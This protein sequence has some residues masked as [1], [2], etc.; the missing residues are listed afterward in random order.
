MLKQIYRYFIS[1]LGSLF[2]LSVVKKIDT[3]LRFNRSLNLESPVTLSDKVCYLEIFS[4]QTLRAKCTDKFEVRNYV[5]AMGWSEILPHIYSVALQSP[6]EL[7]LK[8]LPDSFVIKATHGCRMNY[9]VTDKKSLNCKALEKTINNWIKTTYGIESIE[10]HYRSIP[11]RF[12]IEEYLGSN[13]IDYKIHCLNGVPQFILVCSE[14][15]STNGKAMKVTLNLYDVNWHPIPG[16][17]GYKNEIVGSGNIERPTN[18]KKMLEIAETL[19]SKFDFVRVDLY[20]I[21]KK[22]YFG[23]LT[24][25]PACGVFPY[26]SEDFLKTMGRK[27]KISSLT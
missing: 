9:V 24:F 15:K 25:S 20:E 12:Y 7:R 18:L 19:S 16:L 8:N 11:H 27:L 6:N 1:I 10:P 21:N 26:F 23:E 17:I 22:V 5:K 3:K 14:R 2:D 4:Q 13:L